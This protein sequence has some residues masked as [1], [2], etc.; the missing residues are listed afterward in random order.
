MDYKL[1]FYI[2]LT[3]V[4]GVCIGMHLANTLDPCTDLKNAKK[5]K[6]WALFSGVSILYTW[7][8]YFDYI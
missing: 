2:I 8:S 5:S 3:I 1:I 6:L 7:N 4:H